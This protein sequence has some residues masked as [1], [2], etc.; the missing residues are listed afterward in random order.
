MRAAF[1][2]ALTRIAADDQRTVL[3]TG[4]LGFMVLEPFADRFPN[5]F[6]NVGVA[7]AN[8][9]SAAAGLAQ[10]GFI[11]YCYSIA[12]FASMRGFEQ[13]RDGAV[14]H[15]L[16][17][18][19]VGVG[20]GFGYGSAGHSHWALEDLGMMRTQPGLTVLA[21]GSDEQAVAA[22]RAVHAV[23]GP[24]YLRLA[25]DSA[26]VPGLRDRFSIGRLEVVEN[27]TGVAIVTTGGMTSETVRS[28]RLL[29][30]RGVTP[31]VVQVPCISP[32]PSA[33]L[34]ALAVDHQLVVSVEDHY[35]IGGLGSLVAEAMTD[36]GAS[37]RLIRIG[38]DG[39]CDGLTGDSAWML[40]RHGLTAEAIADV[41]VSALE[42]RPA[43]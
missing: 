10:Q 17:V 12:T 14:Q 42:R 20:G 4:D 40:L 32:S 22:T 21:P 33:A 37:A 34:G 8:M 19:V 3:L 16:P 30:A 31:T 35:R 5:R 18:R 43:A 25:K 27:G 41:V 39:A 9:M 7:E 1:V 26:T 28:A 24:A 23:A 38:V 11:P 6:L 15:N 29:Q 2:S 13:F 36:A